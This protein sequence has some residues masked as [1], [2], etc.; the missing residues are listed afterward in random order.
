[1]AKN[2][3]QIKK[4]IEMEI[5]KS[6]NDTVGNPN[7]PSSE[8]YV[9]YGT[10]KSYKKIDILNF[11]LIDRLEQDPMVPE[12]TPVV[13]KQLRD[14]YAM[15]RV[16][17]IQLETASIEKAKEIKV[18]INELLETLS[19]YNLPFKPTLDTILNQFVRDVELKMLNKRY[20]RSLVEA[21]KTKKA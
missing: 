1:M 19:E 12:C 7:E 4:D 14:A 17:G 3:E 10:Y 11:Y 5:N 16:L 13:A 20:V 21:D 18:K 6:L 2:L 9:K 8:E 15:Y